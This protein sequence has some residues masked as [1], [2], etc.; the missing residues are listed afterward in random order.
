MNMHNFTGYNGNAAG[1]DRAPITGISATTDVG[2][3]V[4]TSAKLGLVE[5]RMI[6]P[7]KQLAASGTPISEYVSV[8]VVSLDRAL[9]K[10]ETTVEGR[11]AFK[12]SLH[13]AGLLTV[14]K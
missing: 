1:V 6:A 9:R 7:A 8:D 14:P 12:S 10:F 5:D 11:L 3:L 2:R 4:E 13:R